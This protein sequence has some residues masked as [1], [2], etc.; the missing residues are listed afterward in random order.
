MFVN[1]FDGPRGSD[2]KKDLWH[3][4]V[5]TSV[6]RFGDKEPRACLFLV[7]K[8]M[9]IEFENRHFGQLCIKPTRGVPRWWST[10]PR[11][12]L[13]FQ[14]F[15]PWRYFHPWRR[16]RPAESRV[17]HGLA[18]LRSQQREIEL[19]GEH[20]ICR[21]SGTVFSFPD[22]EMFGLTRLSTCLP[23]ASTFVVMLEIAGALEHVQL[24]AVATGHG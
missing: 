23:L 15:H 21:M 5:A 24:D 12:A 10:M 22:P 14:S 1:R 3:T 9:L 8:L 6:T 17:L 19:R 2:L 4:V 11:M 13:P 7:L 16:Q 18:V 20:R